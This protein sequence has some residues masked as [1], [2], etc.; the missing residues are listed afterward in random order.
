MS[1]G[2]EIRNQYNEVI[3]DNTP[4]SVMRIVDGYPATAATGT[5]KYNGIFACNPGEVI[6]V[7]STD[8]GFIGGSI[9]YANIA[10]VGASASTIAYVKIVSC[11]NLTASGHGLAVF[12]NEGVPKLV[13]SDSIRFAKFVFTYTG[14]IP[15]DYSNP[16]VY[17]IP[18][19]SVGMN[20]Y[21][22]V[23]SFGMCNT[24]NTDDW[25]DVLKISFGVDTV[26]ISSNRV[27]FGRRTFTGDVQFPISITI[28]EC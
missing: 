15:W 27:G 20:R 19:V 16:L 2:I 13:F 17:N 11:E 25:A 8:N 3:L 24:R 28:I 12:S 5:S 21:V 7:R 22:S 23:S 14:T 6:F 1:Y 10:G 18:T 9:S 26:T 4:Y